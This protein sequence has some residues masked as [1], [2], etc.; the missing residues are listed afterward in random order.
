MYRQTLLH[1]NGYKSLRKIVNDW[2]RTHSITPCFILA[3]LSFKNHAVLNHFFRGKQL[4]ARMLKTSRDIQKIAFIFLYF[5]RRPR[6]VGA[7]LRWLRAPKAKT[8][9]DSRH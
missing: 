5:L 8:A 3:R 2:N 4:G 7:I 9:A 6:R 1:P